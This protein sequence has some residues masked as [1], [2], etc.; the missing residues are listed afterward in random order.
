MRIISARSCLFVVLALTLLAGCMGSSGSD[1]T[2]APLSP[3]NVNLIFVVS[4]DLAYHGDGD[5]N[6]ATANLTNRGLQRSLL[7][8]TY[9]KQQV[10]GGSNVTAIYALQPMT[11]LQTANN[12]P[13]MA[14]LGYI[15]Q[16]ALLNQFIELGSSAYSYPLFASYAQGALPIGVGTPNP[17]TPLCQVLD[18]NIPA[19][20]K[21]KPVRID[22][23]PIQGSV[24]EVKNQLS[25]LEVKKTPLEKVFNALTEQFSGGYRRPIGENRKY[26]A[27]ID[28]RPTACIGLSAAPRYISCRDTYIGWAPE[29]RNR[30]I[31]LI[32]KMNYFSVMPWVLVQDLDLLLMKI[33]LGRI[34]KDWK[35]AYGHNI[36]MIATYLD[37]K[38]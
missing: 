21:P 28:N 27:F 30:S 35:K 9:L 13:D 17:Y 19:G 36:Q 29:K 38:R 12:Y 10:L 33:L 31:H 37:P 11:H 8:A 4:P 1:P 25:F 16:F 24:E 15:E 20:I 2:V 34:Q 22:Q 3:S 6:S 18:F 32:A 26:I 5:I 14:A 23:T 7:M